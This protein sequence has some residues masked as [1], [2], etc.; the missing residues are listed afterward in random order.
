M[1]AALAKSEQVDLSMLSPLSHHLRMGTLTK[2]GYELFLY[3]Q[4]ELSSKM[5]RYR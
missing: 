3:S 1:I 2:V 4:Q 5:L